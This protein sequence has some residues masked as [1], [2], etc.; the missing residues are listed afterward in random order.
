M[1]PL[2]LTS[3]FAVA[4]AAA[5]CATA[6]LTLNDDIIV[7]GERIGDVE[8]GMTLTQLVNLKGVP[9]KT[10]PIPGTA[11]TTYFFDGLTVAADDRV[12]WIIAKDRRFRT[13]EGVK[14]GAEQIFARAAFGQP[15]CVATRGGTT[16]YDYG[17]VYFDVDNNT[18]L[19]TQVG[20]QA[21]TQTC[22]S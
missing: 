3:L 20:V 4:C 9:R 21:E 10:I 12:Y 13:Q 11:A 8:I 6:P 5:A 17:D 22:K 19:V 16:V 2:T 14:V 18:G 15:D 7:P 1:K